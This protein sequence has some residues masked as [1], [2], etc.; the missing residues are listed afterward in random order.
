M[1]KIKMTFESVYNLAEVMNE[2]GNDLNRKCLELDEI[3]DSISESRT[4]IGNDEE[5]YYQV[6]KEK[7]MTSLRSVNDAID[8]YSVFLNK[9]TKAK[10]S[11]ENDMSSRQISIY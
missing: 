7:Y 3:L 10:E 2:L 11:L 6:L 9:S 4:W 5:M 1:Q 8:Q